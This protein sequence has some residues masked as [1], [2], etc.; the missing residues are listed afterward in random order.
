M[1]GRHIIIPAGLNQ[2][3]LD[4]LHLNHMGIEKMKLLMHESVYWVDI[5][6]DI[7]KH[8]KIVTCVLSF[9]RCSPRRRWYTMT[10]P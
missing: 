6:T 2:Q 9:S 10:F 1:K 5:Y 3:A 8:I 4:Q 7:E